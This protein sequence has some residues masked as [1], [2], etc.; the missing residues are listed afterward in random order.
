VTFTKILKTKVKFRDREDCGP[1]PLT[2][3]PVLRCS[4]YLLLCSI[5][6]PHFCP[7]VFPPVDRFDYGPPLLLLVSPSYLTH[8]VFL[9]VPSFLRARDPLESHVPVIV[10]FKVFLVLL[11]F[12]LSLTFIQLFPP[13]DKRIRLKLNPGPLWTVSPFS[14]EFQIKF[15]RLTFFCIVSDEDFLAPSRH[16]FTGVPESCTSSLVIFSI[17]FPTCAIG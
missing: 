11:S 6:F 4:L 2:P 12:E 17:F 5:C 16:L 7:T 3:P 14:G 15:F 13:N 9:L 8:D 10:D 1:W